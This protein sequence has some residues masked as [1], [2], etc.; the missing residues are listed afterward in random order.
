MKKII[1]LSI[2]FCSSIILIAQ[3]KEIRFQYEILDIPGSNIYFESV[4]DGR[5]N[6]KS[7]GTIE[8]NGRRDSIDLKD[9]AAQAFYNYLKFIIPK[10]N[11]KAPIVLQ[12]S[13]I[14]INENKAA[15]FDSI[16]AKLT[17]TFYKRDSGN[18]ITIYE[19]QSFY[20]I[21]NDH[22]FKGFEISLRQC[23]GK[24]L[25]DFINANKTDSQNQ[26]DQIKFNQ[27]YKNTN[28]NQASQNIQI[29]ERIVRKYML[30]YTNTQGINATG[31]AISFYSYSNKDRNGWIFPWGLSV[32]I[33]SIKP[34]YFKQFNF[35]SAKLSYY[36]PGLNAFKKLNDYFW[37]NLG[38]QIPVGSE[39]L[40]DFNGN[41]TD[42]IIF[43]V[44]PTQGLY[45]IPKSFGII[46]GIGVY[47]KLLTSKVYKS[48]IGFKAEIGIK[49]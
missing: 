5:T 33:T 45:F 22:G 7:I 14:S 2:L 30:T 40:T 36:M 37:I 6:Q 32:D 9:G 29:K 31:F 39:I 49:F 12:I 35:Q 24:C 44:A 13:D 34:G 20:S 23:L 3:K 42:N 41:K 19:A 4:M 21:L 1:L 18:L 48:D 17:L 11:S 8:Y 25:T 38:L 43:G 27:T 46:F 47:E 28:V 16:K 10:D 26:T 15:S